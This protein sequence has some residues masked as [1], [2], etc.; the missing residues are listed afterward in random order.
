MSIGCV[1]IHDKTFMHFWMYVLLE[2][3]VYQSQYFIQ[4]NLE[5]QVIAAAA[6]LA[7]LEQLE[8]L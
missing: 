8:L 2:P 6:V 4:L 1:C 5:M 3:Y 7:M